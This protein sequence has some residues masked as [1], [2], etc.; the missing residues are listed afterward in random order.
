MTKP[1]LICSAFG[2]KRWTRRYE[3]ND[4]TGTVYL[5]PEHWAMVPKPLRRVMNKRFKRL[6]DRTGDEHEP[7]RV[8]RTWQKCVDAANKNL[9][10]P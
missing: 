7:M 6:R 1:K 5:C 4:P 10:M 9:G 2:C 3:G 8:R